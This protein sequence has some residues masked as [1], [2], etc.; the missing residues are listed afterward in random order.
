MVTVIVSVIQVNWEVGG[1]QGQILTSVIFRSEKDARDSE[2]DDCS[3]QNKNP[4]HLGFF[5][6]V[7]SCLECTEVGSCFQ[8]TTRDL[9]YLQQ[10]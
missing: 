10:R 2:L 9:G 4:S 3:K 6:R 1:K 8:C 7:P 5:S